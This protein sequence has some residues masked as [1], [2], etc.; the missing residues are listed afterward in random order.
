M[1]R[2]L[3]PLTHEGTVPDGFFIVAD[4]RDLA[5]GGASRIYSIGRWTHD[6][7][8]PLVDPYVEIRFQRGP[9]E[10]NGIN[11]IWDAHLMEILIDRLEGFQAGPF[12]H[13]SNQVAL[14]HIKA[15]L[16]AID[17][18]DQERLGRGVLVKNMD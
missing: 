13:D 16:K 7:V 9:R 18:C 2:D 15:A 3:K 6:G 14:D 4:D 11:G 12:A 8:D 5:N 10:E 17:D 1:S